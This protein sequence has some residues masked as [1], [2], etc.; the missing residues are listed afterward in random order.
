MNNNLMTFETYPD[1]FTDY[2]NN[3]E[4][5]N[6]D[7]E[8]RVFSVPDEWLVRWFDLNGIKSLNA[9]E[10]EYTWDDTWQMYCDAGI[11]G[12]LSN[13]HILSSAR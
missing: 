11:D 1:M 13:V 2:E 9:F 8:M 4:N 12:V 10:S 3:I 7:Y 6:Y 5:E